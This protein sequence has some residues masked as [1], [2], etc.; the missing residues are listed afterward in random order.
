MMLTSLFLHMTK[1]L[2][3]LKDI[4][5]LQIVRRFGFYRYILVFTM[6]LDAHC[7]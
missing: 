5:S 7:V 4:P 6:H 1:R 3:P 2:N